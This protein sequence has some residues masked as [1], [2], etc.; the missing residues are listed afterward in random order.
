MMAGVESAK[1]EREK[2]VDEAKDPRKSL[3]L[4]YPRESQ[5]QNTVIRP[6]TQP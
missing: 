6:K 1:K 4:S 5:T 2:K 3:L